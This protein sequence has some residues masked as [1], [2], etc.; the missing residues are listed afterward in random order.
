MISQC[1]FRHVSSGL[2][3][4]SEWC[5]WLWII[6]Q[7]FSIGIF[8]D[9]P[10][11]TEE[12]IDLRFVGLNQGIMFTCNKQHP[13]QWMWLQV[14]WFCM[15]KRSYL[16]KHC[17]WRDKMVRHG[18]TMC[19]IVHHIIFPMWMTK[20]THPWPLY[21]L[22]YGVC[23]VGSPHELPY[24]GLW[25]V[26]KRMAHGMFDTAFGPSTSWQMVLPSMHPILNM[27]PIIT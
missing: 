6:W 26:F 9:M 21:L 12:I 17:C 22:V 8:F 16:P 18:K 5:F 14:V 20:L 19:V 23:C 3:C 1:G 4:S 10:R 25:L 11:F 15:F 7:L 2:L 24:V 13:T 27:V